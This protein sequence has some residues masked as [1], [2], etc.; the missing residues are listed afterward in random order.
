MLGLS[1]AILPL[2]IGLPRSCTLKMN[3][4]HKGLEKKSEGRK[5]NYKKY[6]WED[7]KTTWSYRGKPTKDN[8]ICKE[9]ELEQKRL[10]YNVKVAKGCQRKI[11]ESW[12]PVSF[13]SNYILIT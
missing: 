8:G 7:S 11:V 2:K 6:I 12:D 4:V 5:G 1:C 3:G 13:N 10:S 9:K